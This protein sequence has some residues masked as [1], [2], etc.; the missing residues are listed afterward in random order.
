MTNP[1]FLRLRHPGH[2]LR[3]LSSAKSFLQSVRP[4]SQRSVVID[5]PR[6][7]EIGAIG[8]SADDFQLGH[9]GGRDVLDADL[10]SELLD[11]A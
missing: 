9:L 4:W 10:G 7:A 11:N 6:V 5:D 3:F 2:G 8:F 1:L